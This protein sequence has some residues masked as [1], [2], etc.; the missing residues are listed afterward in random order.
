MYLVNRRFISFSTDQGKTTFACT[1]YVDHGI[2]CKF[3]LF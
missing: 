1:I 3:K 2:Q